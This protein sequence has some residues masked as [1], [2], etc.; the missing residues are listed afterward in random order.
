MI[1]Q[2]PHPRDVRTAIDKNTKRNIQSSREI[3][4]LKSNLMIQ[5]T[6]NMKI[7]KTNAKVVVRNVHNNNSIITNNMFELFILARRELI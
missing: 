4:T 7:K 6:T 5:L 1:K 2:K 3:T